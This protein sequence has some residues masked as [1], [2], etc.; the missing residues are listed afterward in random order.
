MPIIFWQQVRRRRSTEKEEDKGVNDQN[1]KI[2][3]D[4]KGKEE[5]L[6][7]H[8]QEIFKIQPKDNINFDQKK[9]Q[10]VELHIKQNIEE[11]Q[12]EKRTDFNRLS[13]ENPLI[14]PITAD[15]VKAKISNLKKKKAP[16]ASKINA[17]FLQH[18]TPN[19]IKQITNLFNACISTGHMPK[20]FK[21][22][23]M[24]LIP[25]GKKSYDKS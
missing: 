7:Q 8:W 14:A 6:R 18:V 20:T 2:K 11:L 15:E 22:T 21:E 3:T 24:V 12:E 16:D 25:K 9:E 10:T 5:A 4:P 1:N 17:Q 19:I 23:I 13:W